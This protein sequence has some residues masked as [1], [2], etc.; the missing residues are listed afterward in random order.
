MPEDKTIQDAAE[1]TKEE[2]DPQ[3]A[4]LAE[5]DEIM[6]ASPVAMEVQPDID[7]LLAD[8][9]P[10]E[11]KLKGS[12]K[13]G[14]SLSKSDKKEGVRYN[15]LKE[16]EEETRKLQSDRDKLQ[17]RVDSLEAESKGLEHAKLL[18]SDINNDSTLRAGIEKYYKDGAFVDVAKPGDASGSDYDDDF[19]GGAEAASTPSDIDALVEQKIEERLRVAQVDSAR[20]QWFVDQKVAFH[21][22]HPH[23]S[24][25]DFQA[26]VKFMQD[27]KSVTFSNIY[28]LLNQRELIEDR[29]K[30]LA[31]QMFRGRGNSPRPSIGSM[32]GVVPDEE[33][34][35]QTNAVKDILQAGRR[36]A[37]LG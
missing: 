15:N 31:E 23:A 29:A 25:E 11:A 12:D 9:P 18:L 26:V 28:E 33:G 32:S 3:V 30:Q 1:D 2:Y 20:K 5:L 14:K 37:F 4:A 35:P 8:K 36:E 24:D 13:P 16:A 34:D 21:E 10:D 17:T 6:K 22:A 7:E 19:S 27:P